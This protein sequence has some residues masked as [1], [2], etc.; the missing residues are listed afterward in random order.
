MA[1]RYVTG[2]GDGVAP[3]DVTEQVVFSYER[4]R[5][6]TDPFHIPDSPVR[7][8]RDEAGNVQL[9]LPSRHSRRMIGPE[10][11][12]VVPEPSYGVILASHDDAD[13][14]SYDN[15][16]WV[17]AT[18][19]EDG[20]TVHALV[21]N[22]YHGWEHFP[23][24]CSTHRECWYNAV[25]YATSTDGGATYRHRP[26]PEHRVATFPYR[27]RSKTGPHGYFMPSNIV[28]KDGWLYALI[29]AYNGPRTAAAY[30][31]QKRGDCLIRTRDP[32]DPSSWRGWDGND[33]T[34]RF[35]DPYRDTVVPEQHV[36]E[37]VSL[38][39]PFE[40]PS[41]RY[42]TGTMN[43]SLTYNTH[44]RQFLRI[45]LTW[46]PDAVSGRPDWGIHFSLSNDLVSWGERRL[47]AR[48]YP[49]YLDHTDCATPDPVLYPVVLDPRSGDRN[50]A[51]TGQENNLYFT[52]FHRRPDGRGRC[53]RDGKN[54]DLVKLGFRF[55]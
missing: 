10:L 7:A 38:D 9:I 15:L 40:R 54:R 3:L 22:E 52:V 23:S 37:P 30:P 41:A 51:T 39:A 5:C 6:P 26:S 11:D 18:Y 12:A 28:E 42:P 36:C 21:H 53:V 2:F 50:F 49:F 29:R 14:S 16:E 19:T 20:N 44:F 4:D 17:T 27:Y 32:T 47:L 1:F 35:V 31:A 43:E 46:T 55:E 8:F 25:T 45:G 13:P 33:F 24:D 48:A 34:V